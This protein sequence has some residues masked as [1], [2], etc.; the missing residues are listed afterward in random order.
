MISCRWAYA[1]GV[2]AEAVSTRV[3]MTAALAT[4]LNNRS[5]PA[6]AAR[7]LYRLDAPERLVDMLELIELSRRG[8]L[9]T[10]IEHKVL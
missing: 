5:H 1:N 10:Q 9:M 7:A 4:P 8:S 3:L 2:T 6:Q